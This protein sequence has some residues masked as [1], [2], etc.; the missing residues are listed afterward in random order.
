MVQENETCI[1][2]ATLKFLSMDS[3]RLSPVHLGAVSPSTLNDLPSY[4]AYDHSHDAHVFHPSRLGLLKFTSGPLMNSPETS[5]TVGMLP[6][7]GRDVMSMGRSAV[8]PHYEYDLMNDS[9]TSTKGL[10]T[11]MINLFDHS[12]SA[13]HGVPPFEE[14]ACI[15]PLPMGS[16]MSLRSSVST[17][18][19]RSGS[20]VLP[21]SATK[22]EGYGDSRCRTAPLPNSAFPGAQRRQA[23]GPSNVYGAQVNYGA[24]ANYGPSTN[25]GTSGS[26][27]ASGNF[28]GNY[29]QINNVARSMHL[30][31]GRTRSP[32]PDLSRSFHGPSSLTDTT[33]I[34]VN[35]SRLSARRGLVPKSSEEITLER[36]RV[37]QERVRSQIRQNRAAFERMKAQTNLLKSSATTHEREVS[38]IRNRHMTPAR[39]PSVARA[40][41]R[42]A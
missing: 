3:P 18:R 28:G 33:A 15:P 20:P 30:A 13:D 2:G 23:G 24:S 8:A 21:S 5:D 17:Q 27:G 37:E 14:S 38:G 39:G 34:T 25:Y 11:A 29:G 42:G 6:D 12:G 19:G 22:F 40:L 16:A 7:L 35:C 36:M 4:G 9:D 10:N 41:F 1:T 31:A 32:S 26:C